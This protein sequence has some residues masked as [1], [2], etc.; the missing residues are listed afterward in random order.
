[1]ARLAGTIVTPEQALI[2]AYRRAAARIRAQIHAD[3]RADRLGSAVWR[4]RQLEAVQRELRQLG[5][6]TQ[7]FPLEAVVHDYVR[8]ARFAEIAAELQGAQGA[9]S[10]AF[11]GTHREAAVTIAQNLALRLGD[12]RDLVGRNAADVYRRAALEAI[13]EGTAAGGTRREISAT[14]ARELERDGVTGFVDR[15][16]ARWGLDTYSEM[17]T[18][19][20]TREAMSAG[21]RNRMLETGQDL[22]TISSHGTTTEICIPYEGE[23]FSI[24]GKTEG[25]DVLDT[26]PPFH[27]N[28]LHVATPGGADLQDT[29]DQLEQEFSDPE[30]VNAHVDRIIG[31]GA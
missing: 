30:L 12:A 16:G 22:V 3:L 4:S 18:R 26:W 5:I 13:G 20:T 8:G 10:I 6:R 31:R 19:T 21:T 25:Y 11:A 28:C 15:R 27:P 23:T 9:A 24:S 7:R 17:A 2:Q 14:L 29:L 1:V